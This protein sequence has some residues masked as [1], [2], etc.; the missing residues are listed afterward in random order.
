M[1][2]ATVNNWYCMPGLYQD[3]PEP[4]LSPLWLA[5][6]I[7]PLAR[8]EDSSDKGFNK[9]GIYIP[10]VGKTS[11]IILL[12]IALSIKVNS[13]SKNALLIYKNPNRNI[14][15]ENTDRR[16]KKKLGGYLPLIPLLNAKWIIADSPDKGA[17]TGQSP[18]YKR[19]LIGN[20]IWISMI[21]LILILDVILLWRIYVK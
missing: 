10:D 9:L 1:K 12:P 11:I 19:N 20:A 8:L 3:D 14:T 16:Q 4:L 6:P 7:I 18:S 15:S 21:I 13:G 5:P 2:Y 17:K